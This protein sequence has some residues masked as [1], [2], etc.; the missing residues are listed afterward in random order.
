MLTLWLV[1][2]DVA[3]LREPTALRSLPADER[4]QWASTWDDVR[5]A[6]QKAIRD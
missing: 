1:D 5:Q 6:I 2:P 4:Q 3:D